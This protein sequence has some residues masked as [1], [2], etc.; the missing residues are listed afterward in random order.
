MVYNGLVTELVLCDACPRDNDD[1]W[2]SARLLAHLLTASTIQTPR[3]LFPSCSVKWT[4]SWPRGSRWRWRD[5]RPHGFSPSLWTATDDSRVLE[6]S[7]E[8]IRVTGGGRQNLQNRLAD[9]R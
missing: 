4:V 6:R 8:M 7:T 1:A 2:M 3:K 5:N 9:S